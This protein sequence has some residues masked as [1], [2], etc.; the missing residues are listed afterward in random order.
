MKAAILLGVLGLV[1]LASAGY[2]PVPTALIKT[3]P[4]NYYSLYANYHVPMYSSF[5]HFIENKARQPPLAE[6]PLF[7]YP[8]GQNP[9]VS[10]AS[11]E[12]TAETVIEAADPVTVPGLPDVTQPTAPVQQSPILGNRPGS[13]VADDDTVSVEA[14]S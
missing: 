8:V 12:E 7:H 9:I 3:H 2:I 6:Y 5:V 14:A 10:Q 13:G 1:G 4:I 11:V